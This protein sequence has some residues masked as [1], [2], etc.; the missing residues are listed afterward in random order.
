MPKQEQTYPEAVSQRGTYHVNVDTSH[1]G[2]LRLTHYLLHR[3]KYQGHREPKRRIA[4]R[5][6]FGIQ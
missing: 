5:Y 1:F 4:D 2:R 6:E 3:S